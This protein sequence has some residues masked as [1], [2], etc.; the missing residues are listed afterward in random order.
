MQTHNSAPLHLILVVLALVFFGI[1]AFA[2]PVP[3]EPWR[4]KLIAAGL[5]AWLLSSFF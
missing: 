3:F 1:A 5:F 2:W 4:T